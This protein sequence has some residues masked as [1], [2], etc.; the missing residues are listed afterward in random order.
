MRELVRDH[1]SQPLVV[2]SQFHGGDRRHGIHDN[3]IGR[4]Y[5]RE[6]V[7]VVNIVGEQQVD[8]PCRR[9]QRLRELRIRMFS[10]CCSALPER[11]RR[12]ARVSAEVHAKVRGRNRAY[13]TARIHLRLR[14]AG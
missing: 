3:A 13:R 9:R 11:F 8:G 7:A 6:T 1:Q 2:L 14:V 12:C 5:L 4:K 10:E